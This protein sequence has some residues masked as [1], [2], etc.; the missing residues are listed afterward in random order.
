V[1]DETFSGVTGVVRGPPTPQ[2]RSHRSSIAD[3][4]TTILEAV[5]D[6]VSH[7]ESE[8]LHSAKR[9]RMAERQ[10]Q[11]A[12][13]ESTYTPKPPP[14]LDPSHQASC[15]STSDGPVVSSPGADDREYGTISLALSP[16]N[17]H[18]VEVPSLLSKKFY[19]N[20]TFVE[21]PTGV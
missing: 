10:A 19:L 18:D 17:H 16:T 20:K 6:T 5:P 21:N 9:R 1:E 8:N 12:I 11:S 7:P 2:K 4:A 15:L 13:T 3:A 14:L